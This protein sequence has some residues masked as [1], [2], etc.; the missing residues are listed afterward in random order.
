[1]CIVAG[2]Q[3][4]G[5]PNHPDPVSSCLHPACRGLAACAQRSH[6]PVATAYFDYLGIGD[7]LRDIFSHALDDADVLQAGNLIMQ[8]GNRKRCDRTNINLSLFPRLQSFPSSTVLFQMIPFLLPTV[9][10]NGGRPSYQ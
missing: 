6:G 9:W 5:V 4:G 2:V 3:V 8:P 10:W 1:V 7:D